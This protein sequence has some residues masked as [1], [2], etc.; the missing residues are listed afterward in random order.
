MK[1]Y[2]EILLG[3]VLIVAVV[4]VN[5]RNYFGVWLATKT[6]IKG[7]I[8]CMVALIGLLLA[9]LGISELKE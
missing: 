8:V 5:Y 7:G 2:L 4:W 6:V 9:L 3:I 1:K